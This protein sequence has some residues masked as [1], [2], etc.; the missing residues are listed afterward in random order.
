[1]G[2]PDG[3]RVFKVQGR[4]M[5]QCSLMND[6]PRTI[7]ESER[8]SRKLNVL[9]EC[10]IGIKRHPEIFLLINVP[11]RRARHASLTFFSSANPCP[12]AFFHAQSTSFT[13]TLLE[14][15]SKRKLK[16]SGLQGSWDAHS[17]ARVLSIFN[18]KYK[19]TYYATLLIVVVL[20]K[21]HVPDYL[22]ISY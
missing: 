4:I 22:F 1:M 6:T 3:L 11:G 13:I 18:L 15:S 7:E 20:V 16:H 8:S 14:S 21:K 12:V 2:Q 9:T 10:H 17:Q 5:A 19:L